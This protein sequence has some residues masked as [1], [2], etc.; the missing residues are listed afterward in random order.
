MQGTPVLPSTHHISISN[1]MELSRDV[2]G[3]TR[4]GRPV[5]PLSW[6]KGRSKDPRTNSSI[7]GH[8]KTKSL[9]YCQKKF[10][11]RK[12]S[13]FFLWSQVPARDGMGQTVKIPSR[14]S[15]GKILSLYRCPF[16]LGQWGKFCPFVPLSGTVPY[17]WKP[18]TTLQPPPPSLT[19]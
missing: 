15:C 5:V 9:S 3:Q 18:Y 11:I 19:E 17:H 7:P 6:D 4:T 2:L 12:I 10:V 14:Q 13:L 16:V 8:T 1:R